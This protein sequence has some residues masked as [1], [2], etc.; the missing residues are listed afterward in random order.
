MFNPYMI[1]LGLFAFAGLGVAGWGGMLIAEGR[2][3]RQWPATEGI[4]EHTVPTDDEA[5]TLY[6]SY[7]VNG[8]AYR[9][10]LALP[11]GIPP[12]GEFAAS[13]FE[14][15]PA[16]AQVQ[17]H[18]DPMHPERIT[19]EPGLGRGDWLIFA[20]GIGAMLFGILALLFGK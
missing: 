19:L 4:I 9:Q 10:A 17:V 2:K 18:Y 20:A 13:H 6:V 5:A 15:F 12:V 8:H 16:G 3:T 11:D 7:S 1:I 14:K